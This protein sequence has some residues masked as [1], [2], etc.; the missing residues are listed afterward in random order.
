LYNNGENGISYKVAGAF[1]RFQRDKERERER[2]REMN[3]NEIEGL[4][5]W[6]EDI[7]IWR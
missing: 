2:E 7:N 4:C 5:E 1:S 6:S 3:G